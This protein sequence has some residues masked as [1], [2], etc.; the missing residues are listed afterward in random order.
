V[1]I[2]NDRWG[3]LKVDVAAVTVQG[4]DAPDQIIRALNYFNTQ[5]ELPEV[6]VIV[7]GG[8]SADDLAAFNDEQLVRAIASSR[9]P[10]LTGIGHEVDISLSDLAADVRAATPSNAA[11][12]I[13]PDKQEIIRSSRQRV[14]S[15]VPHVLNVLERLRQQMEGQ[16]ESAADRVE[17]KLDRQRTH[18][19]Q[20]KRLL[21]E[22]DPQRVL[23]RG[24][25]L[26]R[27]KLA[28][29]ESIDIELAKAIIKAKVETYDEK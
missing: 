27:G 19:V 25:A 16:I 4:V 17:Q 24:Y 12:I 20:T 6:V 3:G 21:T 5:E 9:V 11:Q 26:V 23:E 2:L 18:L 28:V 14:Q 29:G 8:G 10:T 7:R 1:K 13:V 15:L 22:L